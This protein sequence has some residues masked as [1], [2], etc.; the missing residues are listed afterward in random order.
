MKLDIHLQK[1]LRFECSVECS[2][3]LLKC[4]SIRISISTNA[5]LL[6]I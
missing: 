3:L 2:Y 1:R 5:G 6:H 4:I